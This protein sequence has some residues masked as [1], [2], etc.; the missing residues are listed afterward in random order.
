MTR[1]S[2][3]LGFLWRELS[4]PDAIRAA[5]RAKFDAVECHWPY[6]T[7]L[8]EVNAALQDSG[9]EMLGI[10][11]VRGDVAAGEIGLSA[12]PGREA[13]ARAAI[14]EAVAYAHSINARN[15][16]VMAGIAQGAA[17]QDTF[18][19][20]VRYAA[21]QAAVHGITILI[22]PLNRYDAPGYFLQTSD[23]AMSL[24]EATGAKNIKLMFD[25]Y[26]V[27]IMEG[28]L[29]RRLRALMP[30]I[31]HVQIAGVPDR[32]EPDQGEVNYRHILLELNALG[33]DI[34]IGAE[35]RPAGTTEEGLGWMT[36]LRADR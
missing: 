29:T 19:A 1:F 3:N 11:T 2:A 12:V 35:Y 24:I 15:I 36:S 22:E 14:D 18:V 21:E 26:H 25:C 20:N 10:N 17:A 6:D 32:C 34:P 13:E 4:L 27:Q 16:H 8:D 31:G 9:L 7:P 33:Y 23:Q 28:D 30:M 5:A